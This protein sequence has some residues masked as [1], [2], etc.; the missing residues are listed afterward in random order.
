MKRYK[1]IFFDWDGTAVLSRKA[2]VDDA[3]AVMRPLLAQGIALVI[4]SGTTYE[5]IAGGRLHT[6]F[7]NDELHNLYLG[8][9]RGAFDYAFDGAGQPYLL[10]ERTPDAQ[11]LLRLHR[12]CFALHTTLLEQYS[13]NT[14]IVF[15]RPNYC[16]LD[17]LAD[18]DRG[19]SLFMQ[20]SEIALLQNTLAAHGIRGGIHELLSLTNQLAAGHDLTVQATTDAKYLEIGFTTKQDNTDGIFCYLQSTRNLTVKDCAFFG[21]EYV[22]V[23]EDIFGSDAFMITKQTQSGDF[24]DVSETPGSRPNEVQRMGGGIEAFLS[25]IRSQGDFLG[26]TR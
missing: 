13:Y 24:F 4:V 5:N 20:A 6:Y 7:S 2:P 22:G 9:G 16:K 12:L 3:V 26:R 17:L 11:S 19:D 1:A 14:D 21:D 15:T 25:F 10:H 23:Q 8:L 18:A